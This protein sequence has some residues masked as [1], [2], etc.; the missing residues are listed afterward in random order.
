VVFFFYNGETPPA[1]VFD[2]FN[3]IEETLDSVK[4]QSYADMV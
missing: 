3:A 4:V 2:E 1:G